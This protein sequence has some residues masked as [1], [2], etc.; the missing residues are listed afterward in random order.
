[1]T[2]DAQARRLVTRMS[3]AQ[4]A[5]VLRV[6]LAAEAVR[7]PRRPTAPRGPAATARLGLAAPRPGPVRIA[8]GPALA[9]LLPLFASRA[10]RDAWQ[11]GEEV[12]VYAVSCTGLADLAAAVQAPMAKIGTSAVGSLDRRLR[13]LRRQAYASHVRHTSGYQADA[14]WDDWAP[15]RKLQLAP[16]PPA[17]PV[18]ASSQSL[19]LA[20]PR[21]WTPGE[22]EA[23][24]NA[25]LA[26]YRLQLFADTD[27]G[28]AACLDGGVDPATLIRYS[29]TPTGVEAATEVTLVRAQA[30]T[31]RLAGLV[32][33]AI[34]RRVRAGAPD[35]TAP[36]WSVLDEVDA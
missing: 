5:A 20:A 28:R 15:V 2:G 11:P 17:C 4:R 13:D 22:V 34:A 6:L 10:W 36:A 8:D 19:I 14:G 3:H 7:P 29:A 26:P 16:T 33:L 18:R 35:P 9:R 25:A 24:V 27:A 1:M 12:H 32:A 21:G 31:P 23:A 30:D